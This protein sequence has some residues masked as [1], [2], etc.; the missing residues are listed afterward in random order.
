MTAHARSAPINGRMT[1]PRAASPITA[2][3]VEP[4]T[5]QVSR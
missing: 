2:D 1:S 5:A 4:V 3:L